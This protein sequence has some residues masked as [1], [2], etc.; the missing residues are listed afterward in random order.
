LAG[1]LLGSDARDGRAVDEAIRQARRAART[2]GSERTQA[3][4]LLGE[5]HALRGHWTRAAAAAQAAM[6][7]SRGQGDPEDARRLRRMLERYRALA[8]GG[9]TGAAR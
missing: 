3:L 1:L 6:A 7:T 9:E 5:A 4:Q 2:G 8:A